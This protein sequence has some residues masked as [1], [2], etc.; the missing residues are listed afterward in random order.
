M[1]GKRGKKREEIEKKKEEKKE[2]G[3]IPDKERR[4]KGAHT[5]NTQ[6]GYQ[7][8]NLWR[9]RSQESGGVSRRRCTTTVEAR[10]L[11]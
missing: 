7:L 2:E 9:R 5:Q 8:S 6:I 10:L 11:S 1:E 3:N 4:A